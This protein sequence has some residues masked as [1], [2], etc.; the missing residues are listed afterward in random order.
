MKRPAVTMPKW[1]AWL[2]AAFAV[3]CAYPAITTPPP[4]AESYRA[5][6]TEPFWSLT[7]GEGRM[8]FEPA[9]GEAVSVAAPVPDTSEPIMR[10]YRT[11]AL[12]VDIL[13]GASCSDG[14]GNPRFVDTVHV[15]ARGREFEGCGGAV[16]AADD[17][18]DTSWQFVE[19]A[20]A[21]I[22]PGLSTYTLDIGPDGPGGAGGFL[23]YSACNRF[24]GTFTRS[25]DTL[26]FGPISA[27]RRG[28]RPP[29][30]EQERRLFRLFGGPV[31]VDFD[32][33]DLILTGSGVSARLR[34]THP[35]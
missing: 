15:T 25:G 5:L 23:G 9:D 1:P 6:G 19:I 18:A 28:C 32:G 17:L 35:D 33:P 3:A 24:G 27:T 22:E 10:R 34:R 7:I 13:V 29:H 20:G 30:D 14:M 26:T 16:L 31:E 8:V 4:N 2:M 11:R 12:S 21:E